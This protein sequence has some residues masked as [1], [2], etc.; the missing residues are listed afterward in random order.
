MKSEVKVSIIIPI[1]NAASYL[2][3]C[4]DSV[5]NQTLAAIEIICIDDASTDHSLAILQEYA[6]NDQRVKVLRFSENKSASQARKEGVKLATGSYIMFLDA[7][8][9]LECEACYELVE[10]IV[11]E[12]VDILQFGTYVDAVPGV[13]QSTIDFF[14]RFALPYTE[15]L[16]N[17]AIFFACF[18]DNKFR[19]NLWNKI[20]KAALCKQAFSRVADGYFPKAQDLYTFFILAWYAQSYFAIEKKYYHYNYGRGI[21]GLNK[22][23]TKPLF[24]RHCL[25]SKVAQKCRQ[26][27]QEEGAWEEY[28]GIWKTINSDLVDECVRLWVDC[29]P[30]E[31]GAPT[32]DILVANWSIDEVVISLAKHYSQGL[33]N[34]AGKCAGAEAF[35]AL[36]PNIADF[37]GPIQANYFFE[38]KSDAEVP[39]GYT[40]LIPIVFAA[41]DN[42]SIF[43]GVAINSILCFANP[44][45]FYR[46]YVLYT[47]ISESH[48]QTLESCGNEQLLVKCINITKFINKS[49]AEFFDKAHFSQ[50]MFYRLYIAEIFPF[51]PLVV[52]LDC[53]LVVNADIAE[54]IPANISDKLLAAVHNGLSKVGQERIIRDFQISPKAYFNSGVLVINVNQWNVEKTQEK[55][56]ALLKSLPKN[57]LVCPDQDILNI[58]CKNRVLYLDAAWNFFWH[59]T[60]E[61]EELIALYKPIAQRLK[62]NFKVLHFSSAVKPWTDP[63]LPL[64]A[65][66]WRYAQTSCFYDEILARYPDKTEKPKTKPNYK[67]KKLS[68]WLRFKKAAKKSRFWLIVRALTFCTKKVKGGLRCLG[69][70]GIV[71]TSKLL[72][73]K[74]AAAANGRKPA[75]E[76]RRPTAVNSAYKYHEK[77]RGWG[78]SKEKRTPQ[79]VVSLTSFP[80]RIKTVHKAVITLL[81]QT[82]KP[83]VVVLWLARPEFPNLEADLPQELLELKTNGLS[84][85]WCDDLKSYKKLLPSLIA[86]P[87]DIIITADDDAYYATDWLELLYNSYTREKGLFVHCHRV[88]KFTIIDDEWQGVSGGEAGY[89]YPSFLNKLVGVGGVLYPPHSLC[90]EVV[91]VE[92]FQKLAATNDDVWFWLMAVLN[93]TRVKRIEGFIASPK[94]IEGTQEEFTLT[95]INDGG[96]KLLLRD[97]HRLLEYYPELQKTLTKEYELMDNLELM[98]LVEPKSKDYAYYAKLNENLY[99][100]ELMIWY[101]TLSGFYLPIER[102][103]TFNEKIQ[104]SKIHDNKVIKTLLT[105]KYLVRDW[106]KNKIGEEYLIP[107]YGQ[108]SSFDDIDFSSLPD[109]FVL[110]A[111]HGSGWNIIVTDKAKFDYEKAQEKI[112][113]WLSQ[114]FAYCYGF[115]LHYRGIQP[116]IIAEKYIG[117]DD[118]LYDY[119]FLCFAGKVKFVWVDSLRYIDHRRDIFDVNWKHQPFTIQYPNAE[120]L[121]RCPEKLEE[122]L[123]VAEVL[124]ADYPHV[125]V[126]LYCT[127][128]KIYFGELTFTGE[129]GVGKIMPQEYDRLLGD[130]FSLPQEIS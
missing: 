54:I 82:I 24:S 106:V 126:D 10:I 25:Q 4:L 108:W 122:M 128:G 57:K 111:N 83:D 26:F 40:K 44:N 119:K 53:D 81:T 95:A 116:R 5:I 3:A 23:I 2:R 12:D 73:K 34:L 129:S 112:N 98:Q 113:L 93:G 60:L 37:P 117:G 86:Y 30:D 61:S 41:D 64:S 74:L 38:D 70:H 13:K 43:V 88:T 1:H 27:L 103:R 65:Y 20:Y 77:A 45:Y 67:S 47:E 118:D 21:T 55:C 125:R 76:K 7:D 52:Y 85:C 92:L 79:L 87:E 107:L 94:N 91:N 62:D 49:K 102:P 32:F 31:E 6:S 114:S 84:I 11:Q 89:L 58:V 50:A 115:E 123:Q 63:H 22:E 101:K 90:K 96:E 48:I 100:A 105:D 14:E 28:A 59:L 110:K 97:F 19:F 66:F 124:C 75:T 16:Y 42:F 68:L 120:S 127:A 18:R 36:P 109:Q 46:V 72:I 39:A 56:L 29:V 121:P 80:A 99:T 15:H 130:L 17:R 71:Y 8:D 104:W 78:L 51:F 69:D 35:K 9:F 33:N